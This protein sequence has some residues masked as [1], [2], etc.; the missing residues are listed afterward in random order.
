MFSTRTQ[1]V[2]ALLAAT[3]A[4]LLAINVSPAD[5][6]R[7][8]DSN[9]PV[10]IKAEHSVLDDRAKRAT[11]AGNVEVRQAE[12]T[13]RSARA[14]LAYTGQVVDGNPQINRIDASGGVI[15]NRPDQTAQSQYAIYDLDRGTILLLGGVMLTQGKN[16]TRGDRMTL[17][18][19]A[20]TARLD[21]V[22][23]GRVT[24]RFSVPQRADRGAPSA[25][26]PTATT[27]Q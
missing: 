15:I 2:L 25:P 13:L 17:D 23:G 20:S 3:S 14:T 16:V 26:K 19:S 7:S 9:A 8:H 24:G 12:M 18:L 10:D 21:A 1:R 5:A 27:P 22:P 6:Q 11:L 4:S